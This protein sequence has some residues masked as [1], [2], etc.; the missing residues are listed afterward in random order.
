MLIFYSKSN[1]DKRSYKYGQQHTVSHYIVDNRIIIKRNRP[2]KYKSAYHYANY[3]EY[4]TPIPNK[5]FV[6]GINE[7]L[8]FINYCTAFK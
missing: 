3:I 6:N 5:A 8:S 7:G 1:S 4:K 2:E